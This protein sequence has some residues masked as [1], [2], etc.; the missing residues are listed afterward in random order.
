MDLFMSRICDRITE[1]MAG[2]LG[3]EIK[4]SIPITA[5]SMCLDILEGDHVHSIGQDR[6]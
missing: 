6:Y 4:N 3:T 5:R 1:G 2:D